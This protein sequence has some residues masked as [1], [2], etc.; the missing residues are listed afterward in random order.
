M[1]IQKITQHYDSKLSK[2]IARLALDESPVVVSYYTNEEN[3]RSVVHSHSYHELVYNVSGSSVLYTGDGKRF[4]MR[5]GEVIFFPA[6]HFH[7]GV[8]NLTDNHSVRLVVQIDTSVWLDAAEKSL[9]DWGDE[10]FLVESGTVAK[11]DLRGLF[12]RMAQTAYVEKGAREMI[13]SAQVLELQLLVN[14]YIKE[15]KA[16]SF[17]AKNEI[18]DRAI[19]YIQQNYTNSAFSVEEL[20]VQVCVS[21]PHLSRLFKSYT[22]ESV[23]EY[24]TDLRMQRCRQLISEGNSILDSSI[25]SGFSDYSSFLKTFKKLYGMTPQQ[26]RRQ[27]LEEVGKGKVEN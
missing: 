9:I 15:N 6:E 24:L 14:Q 22:M 4:T 26:F 5:K 17:K 19:K 27:L 2:E 8:F 16:S 10:I 12:E 7:S 25:E 13:F 21:R 1:V 20:A 23:H 18:I 11:W 3:S